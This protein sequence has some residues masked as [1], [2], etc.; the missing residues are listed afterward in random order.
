MAF[1]PHCTFNFGF[2]GVLVI[3]RACIIFHFLRMRANENYKSLCSTAAGVPSVDVAVDRRG[4]K[5]W[6]LTTIKP[7][8]YLNSLT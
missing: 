1:K 3:A 8:F 7:Q 6:L 2:R 5:E 4:V